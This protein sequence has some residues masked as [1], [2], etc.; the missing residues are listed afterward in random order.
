MGHFLD[1]LWIVPASVFVAGLIGSP[2]C[3]SMCGPIVMNFSKS[4]HA[5]IMYQTGRMI[6]YVSAGAVFGAFGRS[7]F[8]VERMT[9][10]SSLS[11]IL[12]S[13]LLLLNGYQTV[14]GKPLHLP[15]P[16]R[17]VL[18]SAFV[19][20][21][22]NMQ[23]LQ[24]MPRPLAALLT[25]LLTVLIPCGH[26]YSFFVGAITTGTATRGAIF[27]FA[28]WL[29][30]TPLLTFGSFWLRGLLNHPRAPTRRIA[31]L[32]LIA[33]GLFSVLTFGAYSFDQYQHRTETHVTPTENYPPRCH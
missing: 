27:M 32:L 15:M 3:M 33:A 24:K 8:D 7:I 10:L 1:S 20:R 18:V 21:R 28:F 13:A 4:R 29:G 31:G 11:L 14:A 25:G 26:L 17:M 23:R 5:I 22:L 2:H 6:A 19:W 16:K 12:I 9:W 30:S